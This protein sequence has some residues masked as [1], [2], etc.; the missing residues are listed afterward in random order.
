MYVCVS[1]VVKFVLHTL[2]KSSPSSEE[3][4]AKME[5]TSVGK[6]IKH[7]HYVSSYK[8]KH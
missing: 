1:N 7:Y 6:H 2:V 4:K 5:P 3:K 8:C